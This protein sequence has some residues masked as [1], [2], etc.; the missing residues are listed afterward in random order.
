[1]YCLRRR[2]R[3]MGEGGEIP[4]CS[5]KNVPLESLLIPTFMD[6]SSYHHLLKGF[7]YLVRNMAKENAV[8]QNKKALLLCGLRVGKPCSSRAGLKNDMQHLKN[9]DRKVLEKKK[10][11]QFWLW[12]APLFEVEPAP[13]LGSWRTRCNTL[14][15]S[16][17]NVSR[18]SSL[19]HCMCVPKGELPRAAKQKR[20]KFFIRKQI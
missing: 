16:Y 10:K 7:F 18:S 1:M 20:G 11:N 5:I 12:N 19:W 14:I 15:F 8:R 6:L 13:Q 2:G 9:R 4:Q 3:L 17:K